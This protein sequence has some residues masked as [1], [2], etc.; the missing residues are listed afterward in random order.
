MRRESNCL[1][2][3]RHSSLEQIPKVAR[4][5]RRRTNERESVLHQAMKAHEMEKLQKVRSGAMVVSPSVVQYLQAYL[6]SE[7]LLPEQPA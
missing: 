5:K 1:S 6:C 3:P 2:R 4:A 7:R